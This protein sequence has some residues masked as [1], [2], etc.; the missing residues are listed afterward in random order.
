MVYQVLKQILFYLP[1][2]SGLPDKADPTVESGRE[3]TKDFLKNFNIPVSVY[4]P[5]NSPIISS[6]STLLSAGYGSYLFLRVLFVGKCFFKK[7][8]TSQNMYTEKIIYFFSEM[9]NEGK[10]SIGQRT[11]LYNSII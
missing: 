10:N 8:S 11:F 4:R 5:R 3:L 1:K 6:L 7:S 2:I 9:T